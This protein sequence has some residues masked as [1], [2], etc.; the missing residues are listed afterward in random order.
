MH[1]KAIS[2][3]KKIVNNK[4]IKN[5][6]VLRF[7]CT[8]R[9][10]RVLY[11]WLYPNGKKIIGSKYLDYL[12]PEGLAIWYMDDGSTYKDKDR[13]N[14]FTCEIHTH[15]SKEETQYII[16]YFKRKWDIEFHLHKKPHDQY[17]IRCYTVNA[18]KFIS[19]IRPFV[20]D[21][22]DYKVNVS[23]YYFHEIPESWKQDYEIF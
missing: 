20:P 19:L 23:D 16:D 11:K 10:F 15:T 4:E 5:N 21:C 2:D 8:D 13:P 6:G 1:E 14:V 22:M 9:Y 17:T 12:T 3:K 7:T 18:A